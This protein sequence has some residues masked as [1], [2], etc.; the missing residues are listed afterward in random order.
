MRRI[1]KMIRS[2]VGK[3]LVMAITGLA[4]TI[5]LV[6]HLSGNL[7]LLSSNPDPYNKYADFLL[8]FGSLLIVAEVIL[9]A[10]LVFHVFSGISVARGKAAARPER[11]HKKADAGGASKK[12]IAS[13]TMIYTG[14]ITFVF[15]A[16]HLKTFKFGPYYTAVVDGKEIR[17]LHRLVGEVFQN[18]YYVIWYVGALVFLGFHLRHGFWSAFQSLGVHHPRY[19]PLIY[20]I[21]IVTAVILTVGFV[22]IPIWFYFTGA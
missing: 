9:I 12:S 22:G 2:S 5:F 19:T 7:L 11:Y 15:L 1:V 20:I 21:G 8:S 10:I 16:I 14:I 6:E 18:P 17:D 3:K 13:S 4:M